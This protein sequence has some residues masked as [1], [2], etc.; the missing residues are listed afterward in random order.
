MCGRFTLSVNKETLAQA[1]HLEFPD[2]AAQYNIAPTQEVATVLH[3]LEGNQREFQYLRWRLIPSW[4]KNTNE[5]LQPIHHRMPVILDPRDYDLWLN[6]EVL[7]D[8]GLQQLLVPYPA[9]AMTATPVSTK[10]NNPRH[11]RSDCILS[12]SS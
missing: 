6:P 2:I 9:P 4:T 8:E 7:Y 12:S 5:L 3:H 1:F 10:V 11:D